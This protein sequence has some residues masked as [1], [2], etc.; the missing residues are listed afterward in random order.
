[1]QDFVLTWNIQGTKGEP[2]QPV[3]RRNALSFL[4]K[5]SQ[6]CF[7][8]KLFL[9][10]QLIH[11]LII[12]LFNINF[13]IEVKLHVRG[14]KESDN[15]VL[16]GPWLIQKFIVTK[17]SSA[18]IQCNSHCTH[19]TPIQS[20]NA[21]HQIMSLTLNYNVNKPAAAHAAGADPSH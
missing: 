19:L 18:F 21:P 11:W 8:F 13:N 17:Q 5:Q 7:K 9:L 3:H 10:W 20:S 1:M 4:A 16:L 15:H 12:S 6:P 2:N 14:G